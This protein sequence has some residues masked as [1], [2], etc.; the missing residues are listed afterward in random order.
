MRAA[1]AIGISLHADVRT[2]QRTRY[3]HHSTFAGTA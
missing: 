1:S 3:H 2:D